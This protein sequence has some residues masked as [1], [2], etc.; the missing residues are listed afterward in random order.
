MKALRNLYKDPYERLSTGD[1]KFIPTG[2]YSADIMMNDLPT[3]KISVVTGVPKEGKSTFLHR[4]ALN[5]VDK[6]FNVL[7]IDGEHDQN[8]L[9]NSLYS[10]V[11]GNTP[12]AYDLVKY[13]KIDIYEPKP[14]ILEMLKEWHKERLLI[15]SKY[16]AP[17]DNLEELFVFTEK[18]VKEKS[19]DLVIFDNLMVLVNGTQA[20]KNENQGRFMKRTGDLAKFQNTHCIVVAHPNKG[21]VQGEDMDIY[22]VSGNS[23]IVN[24]VDYLIQIRRDYSSEDSADGYMRILLNR[25]VGANIGDIPLKFVPHEGLFEMR[26]DATPVKYEFDWKREG[27]QSLLNDKPF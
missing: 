3:K 18:I 12:K 22:D 13:N 17:I 2:I 8:T 26:R 25:T 4:V 16:L 27:N 21:A 9:V 20:E 1:V 15:F 6:G 11:I 5:A 10:M 14:H 23:E 7:L 24:L 19:I